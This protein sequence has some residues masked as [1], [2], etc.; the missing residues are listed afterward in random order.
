MNR[1]ML[2]R[3]LRGVGVVS[4]AAAG[5]AAVYLLLPLFYPLLLA[6]LLAYAVRPLVRPLKRAGLPGPLAVILSLTAILGSAALILTA[7]I[8][9]LVRELVLLTQSLDT[10]I[11]EWREVLLSWSQNASI[12][13]I[14][15]EINLFYN[16]NP[17][18]HATIDSNVSRTTE[19]IASAL[20]GLV[21]GFFNGVMKLV[22][23]LPELGTVLSVV[24]L[25]AF[26]LA[27]HW[28]RH[29]TAL[30]RLLPVRFTETAAGIWEGL[31]KA[32]SGYLRAQ[33]ILISITAVFVMIGLALLGV[34]SPL[35][36]GL[37]VGLV[38]MLPYFGVGAVMLP[39]TLYAYFTGDLAMA[40]GL[41]ALYGFI[42]LARQLLEPKVLAS[43]V[44]A[45][46]LAMLIGMFA[47]MK[48]LGVAGLL[49]GPVSV[50]IFEAFH[51]AGVFRG[52]R[53]YI[54]NGRIG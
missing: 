39:W 1:M 25:A 4:A 54:W 22:S 34:R 9:R 20:T 5:L 38:D 45:D 15:N 27:N 47:G 2:Y 33:L 43:S 10:H 48:L 46:P 7:V 53:S 41:A 23:A 31:Q 49:I 24:V 35:A 17:D 30:A 16:S 40:A 19:S 13:R 36:I 50:I 28:E 29:N 12:Q 18:Y 8:T 3:T 42:V 52:L 37:A 6:W 32:L 44:G 26:F 14:I 51:R 21:T 11:A